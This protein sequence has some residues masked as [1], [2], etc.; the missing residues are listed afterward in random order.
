MGFNFNRFRSHPENQTST[1][2]AIR[3]QSPE[4]TADTT[5]ISP[6]EQ[7]ANRAR[8]ENKAIGMALYGPSVIAKPDINIS[9][10]DRE[11]LY[12]Q[13]NGGGFGPDQQSALL[14]QIAPPSRA[15]GGTSEAVF[16]TLDD[17]HSRRIFAF[18]NGIPDGAE[19]LRGI[20][21]SIVDAT[22]ERY[23][24]PIEFNVKADEMLARLRTNNTEAKCQE[25]A[26]DLETFK[27]QLYG[28]RQE[29]YE[30]FQELTEK[31]KQ[32]QA[33]QDGRNRGDRI[34]QAAERSEYP[35]PTINQSTRPKNTFEQRPFVPNQKVEVYH[36]DPREAERFLHEGRIEGDP[37]IQDGKAYQLTPEY[38][39]SVGLGPEYIFK[40]G[41]QADIALSR[42]YSAQDHDAVVAYVRTAQGTQIVSYYRSGSQGN[43]RFLPDYTDSGQTPGQVEWF[44]KGYDEESL[45]LPTPTQQALEIVNAQPHLQNDQLH[46]TFAFV[47]TAKRYQDKIEYQLAKNRGELR[48]RHYQEVA[49]KPIFSLGQA[50]PQKPAP[51]TLTLQD[52][53]VAPDFNRLTASYN[54]RSS[55]Y[56]TVA[57]EHYQSPNGQLSW[58]FNRDQTGQAWIGGVEVE[59]PLSSAGLHTQWAQIGNYGTPLYE[60]KSQAGGYGDTS[61]GLKGLY[62]NMWKNYLSHMPLIKK[63]LAHKA[64]AQGMAGLSQP[65]SRTL[66]RR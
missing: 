16:A 24:T 27:R 3:H 10:Q 58:A 25:Y 8:Q 21:S 61:I 14:S 51:E 65:A 28:K 31:A 4:N 46:A 13:I 47:G 60:Y 45:N 59:S 48:G 53:S 15:H 34:L 11:R 19:G 20:S 44:G 56:G 22:L 2:E 30:V 35:S 29:Y 64:Q 63:Y 50:S 38:L 5:P 32:Y 42:I 39:K 41:N 12:Q 49:T 9:G 36:I 18:V 1:T 40:I 23:P 57:S 52:D 62:I 43:W 37:Y 55:I 6:D 7:G 26:R 17:K 54:F 66:D 33:R